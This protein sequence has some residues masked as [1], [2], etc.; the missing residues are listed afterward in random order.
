[1][2]N[3]AQF[4]LNRSKF[5]S[6]RT[7][8]EE[9]KKENYISY[10]YRRVRREVLAFAGYLKKRGFNRDSRLGILAKNSI[11][12]PIAYYTGQVLGIPVVPLDPL[13]APRDNIHFL[14]H[15]GA[16]ILFTD[17]DIFQQ[18]DLEIAPNLNIKEVI[19]SN[20]K[21][22]EQ[23]GVSSIENIIKDNS[24]A[25]PAAVTKELEIKRDDP[26]LII[27]T[28]GTTGS[29]KG[30]VLS[31][32]NILHQVDAIPR[33]IE[34][35]EDDVFIGILPLFHMFP[36]TT[37]MLA[38]FN[39]GSK[40]VFLNSLKATN[41]VKVMKEKKVTIMIGVPA[42][43]ESLKR[44]IERNIGNASIFK[45]AFIN[46]SRGISK[47]ASAINIGSPALLFKSL[48][49]KAGM[50]KLRLMVSGGAPLM[51]R[52]GEF[53][54]MLGIEFIQGYG[55]TETSPVLTV[56][57]RTGAGLESVGRPLEGVDIRL[58]DKNKEGIGK[59]EVKGENVMK[60]YYDNTAATEKVMDGQWFKTGDMGYVDQKGCLYIKG[61]NKNIIV[62]S[63]GKNI[64]PEEIE[65]LIQQSSYILEIMV[66]GRRISPENPAEKVG[67]FIYP[68]YNM[69]DIYFKRNKIEE[70]S[71]NIKKTIKKEVKKYTKDLPAYKKIKNI[72][73]Q[74]EEFQKTT[75]RK[76]KRYLYTNSE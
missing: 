30:V 47:V 35:K 28:S 1:M 25:P 38:P 9:F 26:A 53:F 27:Y 72:K 52:T 7:A 18:M 75:T 51:P 10:S 69:L 55:L 67:A 71:D 61:R 34:F 20:G 8:Y 43:F 4:F 16:D 17:S 62:S 12:W 24:A 32:G 15:A 31:H 73:I 42:L 33:I 40:V 76:I 59:I 57:Y 65:E 68:D 50:K 37:S 45:R 5:Y 19:L 66:Y 54:R 41:I 56:N 2:D 58:K 13:L 11:Y 29:P 49:N 3:L 36:S 60:G 63:A 74:S 22:Y 48:K 21:V 64:Y 14:R 44:A 6:K 39:S 70:T 46:T 23:K